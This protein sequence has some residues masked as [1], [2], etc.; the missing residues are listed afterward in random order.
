MTGSSEGI[1]QHVWLTCES[2]EVV[3]RWRQ[4]T[5]Y[6]VYTGLQV[7][8]VSKSVTRCGRTDSRGQSAAAAVPPK[9]RMKLAGLPE[10]GVVPKNTQKS[11]GSEFEEAPFGVGGC[12]ATW[13]LRSLGS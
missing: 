13:A 4:V 6:R 9:G 5:P 12:G 1:L 11:T 2:E 10:T 3:S 8:R 7:F